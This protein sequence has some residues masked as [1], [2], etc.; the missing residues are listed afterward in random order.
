[1]SSGNREPIGAIDV[2]AV[3]RRDGS[4]EC[5]PFHARFNKVARK[6]EKNIVKLLV[7]GKVSNISMKLGSM[8][9]VTPTP[10]II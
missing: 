9:E 4:I 1:M 10:S 6:G 5:T 2:I 3:R 8:G 7:N